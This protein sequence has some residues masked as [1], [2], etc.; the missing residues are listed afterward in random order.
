MEQ[1]YHL[2]A[3]KVCESVTV[4]EDTVCC[5]CEQKIGVY[6]FC[7]DYTRNKLYHEYCYNSN[8]PPVSQR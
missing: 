5:E 4:T 1:K 7:Y 8:V 6:P 2:Q 3:V